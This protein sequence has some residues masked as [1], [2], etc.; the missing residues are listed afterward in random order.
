MQTAELI[1]RTHEL[2]R[3]E[4]GYTL[5]DEDRKLLAVAA[6]ELSKIALAELDAKAS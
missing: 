4:S 1:D 2:S 6:N 5:T 3:S